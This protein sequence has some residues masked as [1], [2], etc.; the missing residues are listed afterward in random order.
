[1]RQRGGGEERRDERHEHGDVTRQR[2]RG[3]A[4]AGDDHRDEVG[5][6]RHQEEGDRAAADPL[7]GHPD[8]PQRP[9]AERETARAAG[10]QQH[11]RRLLRHRDLVAE[12][13]RQP[14]REHASERGDEAQAGAELERK[15]EPDQGRVGVGEPPSQLAEARKGEDRTDEERREDDD[16][17]QSPA[18]PK[19]V[20]IRLVRVRAFRLDL[21]HVLSLVDHGLALR[22][23]GHS[24]GPVAAFRL[25]GRDVDLRICFNRITRERRWSDVE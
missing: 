4:E 17:D 11:V 5:R 14:P 12:S 21:V 13:P 9:R 10:R 25:I 18:A 15:R 16:L 22:E 3:E 23:T 19:G 8:P 6:A 20:G 2:A 1:V 7:R 24:V